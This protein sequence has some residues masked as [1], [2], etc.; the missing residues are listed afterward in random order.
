MCA[1]QT[2]PPRMRATAD[3]SALIVSAV[4]QSHLHAVSTPSARRR[5]AVG[6]PSARRQHKVS[7]KS[8]QSQHAASARRQHAVSTPPARDRHGASK[9]P[10]PRQHIFRKPPR[11]RPRVENTVGVGGSAASR[12][13]T[14]TMPW[15]IHAHARTH[16]VVR[17]LISKELHGPSGDSATASICLKEWPI[18][19]GVPGR[20]PEGDQQDTKRTWVI[21]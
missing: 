15:Y 8:A 21:C 5:H 6:T 1:C 7:T 18:S 12:G 13:A 16:P 14:R 3:P 19:R 9:R 10:A 4:F 2:M 17:P 20:R 11:A